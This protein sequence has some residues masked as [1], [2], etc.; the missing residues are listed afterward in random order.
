MII[1][2]NKVQKK[3]TGKHIIKDKRKKLINVQVRKWIQTTRERGGYTQE[4]FSEFLYVGVE[5]YQKIE[6]V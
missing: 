5:H 4:T 3:K 6:C 2:T 1:I